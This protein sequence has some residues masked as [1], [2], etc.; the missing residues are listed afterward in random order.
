MDESQFLPLHSALQLNDI[1]LSAFNR[2]VIFV[3]FFSCCV[4]FC[5]LGKIQLLSRI[6]TASTRRKQSGYV[7]LRKMN[8][9]YPV[10]TAKKGYQFIPWK[11][12]LFVE[13]SLLM[14][15]TFTFSLSLPKRK[16]F[17]GIHRNISLV[18]SVMIQQRKSSDCN[19][20]V[21]INGPSGA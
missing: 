6:Q 8:L 12:L 15:H 20:L 21:I 17:A 18:R 14:P 10:R 3:T 19:K 2:K 13:R 1:F 5:L 7:R 9:Q 4:S 16:A 11:T